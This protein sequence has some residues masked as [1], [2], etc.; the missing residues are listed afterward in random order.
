VAAFE[1][2]IR[3]IYAQRSDKVIVKFDCLAIHKTQRNQETTNVFRMLVICYIFMI[4]VTTFNWEGYR[5][6]KN[7]ADHLKITCPWSLGLTA[8]AN[9]KLL[10]KG[11]CMND[12][13]S[14]INI[15]VDF[16]LICDIFPNLIIILKVSAGIL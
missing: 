8:M 12:L 10:H 9:I 4:L 7:F 14:K 16:I 13:S 15:F 2:V 3:I 5:I 11:F 1:W 6:R